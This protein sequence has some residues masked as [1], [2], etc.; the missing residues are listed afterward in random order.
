MP[1]TGVAR[2]LMKG[3]RS[4]TMPT[5]TVTQLLRTIR[6]LPSDSPKDDPRVWYRTQKEHWLGWLSEYHGPG[7]YGRKV[8]P[9]RDAKYAYNHVVNSK[10]L[11]YLIEAAGL[12][13]A[14]VLAARR[15]ERAA[16]SMP[17]KSGA[18]RRVVPWETVARAL[19]AKPARTRRKQ[20]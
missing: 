15:A 17:A 16:T 4:D 3:A 13:H 9:L 7:A 19:R 8:G 11:V 12:E 5:M 20:G 2:T 6:Q 1:V 10:M 14:R 18:V